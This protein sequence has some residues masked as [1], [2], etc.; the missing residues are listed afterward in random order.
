MDEVRLTVVANEMEAEMICGLL[1][2]EGIE[3]YFRKTDL[4]AGSTGGMLTGFGQTEII[5]GASDLEQARGLL[6]AADEGCG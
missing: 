3:C 4:G 2:S 1:R 6:G 5:V